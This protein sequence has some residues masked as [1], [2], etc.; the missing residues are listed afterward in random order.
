MIG[1]DSPARMTIQYGA[2]TMVSSRGPQTWLGLSGKMERR[3]TPVVGS[4]VEG[5]VEGTGRI[6]ESDRK[7]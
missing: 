5:R 6:Q 7:G 3:C 4:S 1:D 2:M